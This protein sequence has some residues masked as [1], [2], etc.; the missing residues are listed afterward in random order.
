MA[1][2]YETAVN[3]AQAQVTTDQ[4]TLN[5]LQNDSQMQALYSTWNDV[6]S[7]YGVNDKWAA[8]TPPKAKDGSGDYYYAWKDSSGNY[9][10]GP[11]SQTEHQSAMNQITTWQAEIATAQA[12]LSA[13]T[14]SLNTLLNSPQATVEAQ[15][16]T[17]QAVAQSTASTVK[18]L[19]I[20]GSVILAL[21][22]VFFVVKHLKSKRLKN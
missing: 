3:A 2:S 12:K 6:V 17:Q 5:N 21:I 11:D 19:V 8:G 20:G 10:A 1:T 13:D 14:A 16:S 4:T 9:W 7:K 22:I 18:Y 15:S